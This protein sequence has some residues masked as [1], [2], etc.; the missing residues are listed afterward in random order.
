[1]NEPVR[2]GRIQRQTDMLHRAKCHPR[3]GV[4]NGMHSHGIGELAGR[5]DNFI[6]SLL[7][8]DCDAGGLRCIA[9]RLL[10]QGSPTAD[11]SVGEQLNSTEPQ[12]F[13]S[14][15]CSKPQLLH[16]L[17]IGIIQQLMSAEVQSFFPQLAVDPQHG[18]H[19]AQQPQILGMHSG[20]AQ[21]QRIS[22]TPADRLFQGGI[23]W[24]RL[25]CVERLNG[26][27]VNP[28]VQLPFAVTAI[29]S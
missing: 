8:M 12:P 2:K 1:M 21:R 27:L 26:I 5:S 19:T 3:S 14:T 29:G 25:H 7:S 17:Q 24:S 6:Q 4:P 11:G 18:L 13:V 9:V 10:Q 23:I 22:D 28:A 16:L 15:A 20:Q